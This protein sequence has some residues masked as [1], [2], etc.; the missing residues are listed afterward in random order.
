MANNSQD[1]FLSDWL[2]IC[3]YINLSIFVLD[4]SLICI[5]GGWLNCNIEQWKP[6]K[7]LIVTR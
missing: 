5:K 3:I 1:L 4:R 7:E 2:S 6:L